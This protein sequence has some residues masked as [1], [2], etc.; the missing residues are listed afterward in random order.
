MG[1][2]QQSTTSANP[3]HYGFNEKEPTP[4]LKLLAL[5]HAKKERSLIL[6]RVVASA[7]QSPK[8]GSQREKVVSVDE[9][10][11]LGERYLP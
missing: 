2:Q 9:L 11:L 1:T 10:R 6:P 4:Q 8:R 7:Q 5:P 3:A